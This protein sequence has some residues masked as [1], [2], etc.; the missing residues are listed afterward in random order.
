MKIMKFI[1][2]LTFLALVSACVE[3]EPDQPNVRKIEVLNWPASEEFVVGDNIDLT[4]AG[5]EV[6]VTYTDDSSVVLDINDV[7]LEGNGAIYNASENRYYLN[8]SE[9]G[10]YTVVVRY[11]G[12]SLTIDYTLDQG[13][14]L[15]IRPW[16]MYNAQVI[17]YYDDAAEEIVSTIP[18]QN[19]VYSDT[20]YLAMTPEA[21]VM[22][23]ADFMPA[24]V[25]Q[26]VSYRI[27]DLNDASWCD[28]CGASIEDGMFTATADGLFEVYVKAT[29]KGNITDDYLDAEQEGLGVYWSFF[30]ISVYEP[31][32]SV[33][34]DADDMELVIG[35]EVTLEAIVSPENASNPDVYWWT[36]DSMVATIDN[37]GKLK[38]VN[39]GTTVVNV[40]TDEG[41]FTDTIEVTV[42]PRPLP[43]APEEIDVAI[44]WG[45]DGSETTEMGLSAAPSNQGAVIVTPEFADTWLED[46]TAAGVTQTIKDFGVEYSI[47]SGNAQVLSHDFDGE[48]KALLVGRAY[49]P[50]VVRMETIIPELKDTFFVEFELDVVTSSEFFLFAD[51]VVT[52]YFGTSMDLVV[53]SMIQGQAVTEIGNLA[54]AFGGQVGENL[55][56]P[57]WKLTS[58]VLPEGILEIGDG[59][60]NGN[61]LTEMTIPES[62]TH[63]HDMA[64]DQNVLNTLI[65]GS[66]VVH[67]GDQAFAGIPDDAI[68]GNNIEE[69]VLPDGLTHLGQY[70]FA[71]NQLTE[72]VVPE[73]IT[74]L[75]ENVFSYNQ[76]SSVTLLGDV[77][78]IEGNAFRSNQLTEIVLPASLEEIDMNAFLGNPVVDYTFNSDVMINHGPNFPSQPLNHRATLGLYGAEFFIQISDSEQQTTVVQGRYQYEEGVWTKA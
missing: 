63:I 24:W 73:G 45:H 61:A 30:V 50:V 75:R 27:Y 8:L 52:G 62:V 40:V 11:G 56:R 2:V 76:L 16:F 20:P 58:V 22:L 67:I 38:A 6:K 4:A 53:P 55:F 60:F 19:K 39:E 41:A 65:L 42:I 14:P 25:D 35:D 3:I 72:V 1:V 29:S 44:H 68:N 32:Q 77:T 26:E 59:A 74:V 18:A 46:Y 15:L 28:D 23:G 21:S 48:N 49:G 33:A 70:A 47:V 13:E 66:N 69:V 57:G 71:G 37:Q 17:E 36:T 9:P 64:F 54:L 78:V 43:E 51:G 10:E 5:V 34:I 12:V 7:T 31:V